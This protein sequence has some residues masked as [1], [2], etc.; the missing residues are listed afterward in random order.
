MPKFNPQRRVADVVLRAKINSGEGGNTRHPED[1]AG[2][3][4]P[5]KY[6]KYNVV[7]KKEKANR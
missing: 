6:F 2:K 4:L 1:R 3:R 5:V 7:K